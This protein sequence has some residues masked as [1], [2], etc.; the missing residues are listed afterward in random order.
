M[1]ERHGGGGFGKRATTLARSRRRNA[2]AAINFNL[3]GAGGDGT[4]AGFT[5]KDIAMN[6]LMPKVIG[7]MAIATML[8]TAP[9]RAQTSEVN[10]PWCSQDE[11]A[12]NCLYKTLEECEYVV[13]PGGGACIPNPEIS[14]EEFDG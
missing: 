11:G 13:R 7:A 10:L 1:Q 5:A 12:T 6:T 9:G 8:S 3:D 14:E 4:S 2:H